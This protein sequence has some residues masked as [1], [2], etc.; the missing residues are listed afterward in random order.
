MSSLALYITLGACT[1]R[2]AYF[3]ARDEA[4]ESKRKSEREG[5]IKKENET[6]TVG[7]NSRWGVVAKGLRIRTCER[8]KRGLLGLRRVVGVV[9]WE[10]A[11]YEEEGRLRKSRKDE[12]K[13]GEASA[14]AD[15]RGWKVHIQM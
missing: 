2:A 8:R 13:A 3:Q 1:K 7:E 11:V 14:D 12:K 9:A 15:A 4:T 6:K 5:G 10:E